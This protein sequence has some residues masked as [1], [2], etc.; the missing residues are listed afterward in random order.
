MAKPQWTPQQY[1]AINK[2]DS[3]LLLTASAGSGKTAVLA[4]RYLKLITDKDQPCDIERIL[5]MTFTNDAVAEMRKRIGERLAIHV[6]ENP[7][8]S[9]SRRQYS[10][11][12]TANICTLDS[13]SSS[14]LK[15]FFYLAEIDPSFEIIEPAEKKLVYGRFTEEI[16]E[17]FYSGLPG[18]DATESFYRFVRA[19]GGK[20][21]DNQIFAILNSFSIFMDIAVDSDKWLSL[22]LD[23]SDAINHRAVCFKQTIAANFQ[24][25]IQRAQSQLQ[26][27]LSLVRDHFDTVLHFTDFL[28]QALESLDDISVLL[29]SDLDGRAT[30]I[31]SDKSN[32][33]LFQK[34][35]QLKKNVDKDQKDIIVDFIKCAKEQVKTIIGV[36]EGTESLKGELFRDQSFLETVRTLYKEC[37]SRYC[38]FKQENN[39]LDYRDLSHKVLDVIFKEGKPTAAAIEQ[40]NT[41]RYILVDEYQDI[42]PLQELLLSIIKNGS[43]GPGN[44]FMVGDVKQ[45][46][47]RFRQARPEIILAKHNSYTPVFDGAVDTGRETPAGGRI[48]L[49]KNFRSRREIVNFVNYFFSRTMTRDFGGIDY[50]HDGMMEYG[51]EYYDQND[52]DYLG[53]Q[54][55]TVEL[56]LVDLG[57]SEPDGFESLSDDGGSDDLNTVDEMSLD[58]VRKE[59]VVAAV[60]ICKMVGHP[61]GEPEFEVLC[62]DAKNARGVRFGDIAVLL[63]S[64]KSQSPVYAEVFARFGIPFFLQQQSGLLDSVEVKYIVS[65]LMLIDNPFQDISLAAVLRGPLV[66]LSDRQ[67]AEIRSISSGYFYNAVL[68]YCKKGTDETI[69]TA[70]DELLAKLENWRTI[71]R[72][73]PLAVLIRRIYRSSGLLLYFRAY[74]NG[75]QRYANLLQ[76]YK[77]ACQFDTFSSQGV[78]RF[79]RHLENLREE[80]EPDSGPARIVSEADNVVRIM[81]VHKSK[82]LEY[83]VVFVAGL[84]K[85]FNFMSAYSPAL[86]TDANKGGFAIKARSADGQGTYY[87]F[88][89]NLLSQQEKL[90]TC[91]EELRIAYVAFT[92]AREHLIFIGSTDTE[93]FYNKCNEYIH[94]KMLRSLVCD[95]NAECGVIDVDKLESA[96]CLLDWFALALADHCAFLG[97][98]PNLAEVQCAGCS[99]DFIVKVHNEHDIRTVISKVS[100]RAVVSE[101]AVA[102]TD[103]D[104][105][106]FDNDEHTAIL[107]QIEWQYPALAAVY[108]GARAGVTQLN[109]A[110]K[111]L[112]DDNESYVVR[113]QDTEFAAALPGDLGRRP[114]FMEIDAIA[115]NAA[116][117]GTWTHRYIELLD[118][119]AEL[120]YAGLHKQLQNMVQAG[121]LSRV[122]ADSITIEGI[123]T[124][125]RSDIGLSMLNNIEHVYRE[126]EFTLAVTADE[127]Y[128]GQYSADLLCND[129]VVVR[130]IIDLLYWNGNAFEVIDFKTDNV[131]GDDIQKRAEKY[132]FQLDFYRRAVQ[133]ITG[134]EVAACCLYFLKPGVMVHL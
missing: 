71:S 46:I 13:Y 62:P 81:S 18:K 60:R 57:E 104:T 21:G 51:A 14:L 127:L 84:S 33:P 22:C 52:V 133:E 30:N 20:K 132:R 66:R 6:R 85:K 38:Q 15:E 11:F 98:N 39:Y 82:G 56:H 64:L 119:K 10:M 121:Q 42:S 9:H 55:T 68:E 5:V 111:E 23:E 45:S 12:G 92:R 63:R 114:I 31:L 61:A 3:D 8:D 36:Y 125:F 48:E 77:I 28:V 47:Y 59:A 122:Q 90:L 128:T 67:L 109:A 106:L 112:Q 73:E 99:N 54:N 116:E 32:L 102:N 79:L 97:Y 24:R 91:H 69:K 115:A 123:E 25:Q 118:L 74:L 58:A 1:K 78:G 41:F 108:C 86:F 124:F 100:E 53:K 49:N 105:A 94:E 130:G 27:A 19:Y 129:K 75:R 87:T 16:L 134:K 110:R 83:P 120:T 35:P 131:I 117:L 43:D 7:S 26:Q 72:R 65:I 70:L 103:V 93:K 76:L 17:E 80:A 2:K 126:W 40:R 107:K 44:M 96:A 34:Y 29:R 95:D 37:Q 50:L 88:T 4:E 101:I 89:H 113:L